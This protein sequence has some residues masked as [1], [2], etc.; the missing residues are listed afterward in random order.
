MIVKLA[1]KKKIFCNKKNKKIAKFLSNKCKYSNIG[2][3]SLHTIIYNFC[4]LP[5]FSI[6]FLNYTSRQL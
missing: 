5:M 3:L 1:I 2:V 4:F 6:L